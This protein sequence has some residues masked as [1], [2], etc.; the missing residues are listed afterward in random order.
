MIDAALTSAVRLFTGVRARWLECPVESPRSR[1]YFANHTSHL[2]FVVLWSVLPPAARR[3]TR[4]AAAR[5]YWSRG[6]LRPWLAAH[7]FRAALIEREHVTRTNN[8]VDQLAAVLAAGDSVIL[9]PEG[10]RGSGPEMGDFK[11]GLYHLAKRQ[12]EAELVPAYIENLNRVLPKGEVLA[13]PLIC[14]VTFGPPERLGAGESKEDF[15][16]R[17]RVAVVRL[18]GI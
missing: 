2:D 16:T 1:I 7:V 8:P 3:R 5:D 10:T 6:R 15:L 12:P 4:P 13:V 11:S 14:H 9:F 18:R 17:M